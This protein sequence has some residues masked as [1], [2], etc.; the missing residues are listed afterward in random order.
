MWPGAG[1]LTLPL[2]MMAMT[3]KPTVII[4]IKRTLVPKPEIVIA[5]SHGI[6]NTKSQREANANLPRTESSSAPER[7]RTTPRSLGLCKARRPY[8]LGTNTP[9]F[10][11]CDNIRLSPHVRRVQVHACARQRL[12]RS[13]ERRVGKECRTRR[14]PYDEQ[15]K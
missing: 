8:G 13:E 3:P 12:E 11:C 4:P 1:R 2:S 10:P 14:S 7:E 9:G 6:A 15:K 5:S